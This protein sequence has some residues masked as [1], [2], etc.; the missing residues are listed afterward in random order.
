MKNKIRCYFNNIA[1]P[2]LF[3]NDKDGNSVFRNFCLFQNNGNLYNKTIP[4][5]EAGH[6]LERRIELRKK[7]RLYNIIFTI[8]LYFIFLHFM[9]SFKGLLLFEAIWI[10]LYFAGRL[11]ATQIY[12]KILIT[13]YGEYIVSD[14]NPPIKQ[15]KKNEYKRHFFAKT[16]LLTM[17]LLLFVSFSFVLSGTIRYCANKNKPNYNM[18]EF[19]SG[20]Y[21]KL[22]PPISVIY[23][24][25]AY[26]DY[27]SGD[28]EKATNNYIK[29]IDMD[30][31]KK[32]VEKNYI[33]FAN[34]LYL[35]K[36]SH[37]SQTAIDIFNEYSTKLKVTVPQQ[38]KL[39]WIKS[40]FSI[41]SEIA[42]FVISDY[43]DLLT[44]LD[45]ND[46]QNRFYI[47]CDKAYMLYLMGKYKDAINIYNSIIPYA[48][49]NKDVYANDIPRLLAERGFA[50]KYLHD[51]IGA[52]SD[53]VESKI[54]LYEIKKYEPKIINPQF[55]HE[56]F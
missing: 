37:G 29:V 53:F 39:L 40:M 5:K 18:A 54:N 51:S 44:S 43:D 34:L 46:N 22:Y 31:N 15:E 12:K 50:K 24:I 48:K 56:K 20:I 6:V 21:L 17:A 4:I 30:S 47:L 49:E 35:I 14:F 27:I 45:K 33:L 1:N 25:R 16:F 10:V 2:L 9:F 42:D 19:L 7:L 38:T 8:V 13:N 41:S 11:C 52:N 32:F 28:F 23:E 55:I 3:Y 36:K 26:E